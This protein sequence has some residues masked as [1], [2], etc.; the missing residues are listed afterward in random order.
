MVDELIGEIANELKGLNN[1]AVKLISQGS[2]A[3]AEA[4]CKRGFETAKLLS[5]YDGM[6]TFLFN[7]ANMEAIKGDL[8]KALTYGALCRE[9][10]E[11]AGT[12]LEGS[13]KLLGSL[14]KAAMKKGMEHEKKGELKEALEYY[15]ASVPFSE[16]KYR[17]AML[18]EIE[19]I[20]K[21][22]EN[23]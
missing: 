20:E 11:T 21:V 3:E 9:M 18:K 15:Y 23:G 22:H 5:Y 19:L 16:E 7:L 4:L 17:L 1:Q 2:F 10:H 8:L 6:A 12:D 14:A 13:D